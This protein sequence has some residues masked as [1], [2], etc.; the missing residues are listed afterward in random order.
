ML[1]LSNWSPREGGQI[2]E[3]VNPRGF[4]VNIM[5]M[6]IDTVGKCLMVSNARIE[7]ELHYMNTNVHGFLTYSSL[8]HLYHK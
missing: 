3:M 8:Q 5:N 2:K 1:D 7:S 6:S 4:T